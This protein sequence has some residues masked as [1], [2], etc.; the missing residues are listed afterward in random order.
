MLHVPLTLKS[1]CPDLIREE[2]KTDNVVD[3]KI[4]FDKV[5][6]SQRNNNNNKYQDNKYS[7]NNNSNDNGNHS[8]NNGNHNR[9]RVVNNINHNNNKRPE[10]TGSIINRTGN[11]IHFP[12]TLKKK[13]CANFADTEETCNRGNT[14][15]FDHELFP[16]GYHEDDIAPMVK[17]IDE[18]KYLVWHSNVTFPVSAKK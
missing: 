5:N 13:Y 17:F 15:L 14:C 10:F 8:N 12:W 18:H 9:R 11:K 3:R 1:F 4:T 2:G 16:S 6:G 7:N